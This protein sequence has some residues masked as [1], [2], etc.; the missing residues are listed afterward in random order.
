MCPSDPVRVTAQPGPRPRG[1]TPNGALR[2][3]LEETEW[4]QAA[5]A[6]ALARLG[7]EVGVHLRYDRTSV[8]HWL[9][10]SRP[11]PRVQ[12]LMAEALSRR[13]GRRVTVAELGMRPG[14]AG[15]RGGRAAAGARSG[16]G[17]DGDDEASDP[18][19]AAPRPRGAGDLT[20]RE[21]AFGPGD[22]GDAGPPRNAR[23]HP[24]D[25][26]L[27][28]LARP[29]HVADQLTALTAPVVPPPR[30]DSPPWA[31]Y[32]LRLLTETV[33]S[34]SPRHGEVP[35]GGPGAPVPA[36]LL[37]ARNTCTARGSRP[38]SRTGPGEVASVHEHARFFALQADRHGGGHIRTSLAAFLSGLVSTLRTGEEGVHQRGMQAGAAR[39]SFLLA[40][41][42][43][44]EQRHGL[45]QR[46]FLTAAEL[47]EDAADPD[48]VALARRALSSQ[49]HQLGHP[50]VSLALAEAALA[51]AP[52]DADPATRAFLYAGLAVAGAAGGDR[53]RALEAMARAERQ[54]ARAPADL[55]T[56]PESPSG[57][58]VGTY[59]HA[60]LLYQSSQMRT[61]L[62]DRD[63]AIRDLRASL[64]A[65]PADELRSRALC[66][67]ELAELLL[68]R[69]RLEEACAAWSSF[70]AESAQVS[71][72]RVRSA[73]ARIPG[74]LRPYG[75]DAGVRSLLAQANPPSGTG[76]SG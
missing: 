46:A 30:A 32:T 54:L 57:E 31:P 61:A 72:G 25:V 69:G 10:G 4:T 66:R 38:T 53:R 47:A 41:V 16:S 22:A 24:V 11:D 19:G 75:R 2:A 71:S 23:A 28:G 27:F 43:A 8:A 51:A 7:A 48:G 40:R 9:R 56:G 39:L 62:G 15:A 70:L 76:S 37:G 65:R 13:L 63:G 50:R 74:L 21:H 42:Y 60:A 5:F 58:P 52:A 20:A 45:A 35:E 3:L 64:G 29:S 17:A 55:T 26:R 34:P 68:S 33:R 49:A 67:A 12:H 1:R 6:R 59:R 18:S 36:P 73:R 44:D 14:G